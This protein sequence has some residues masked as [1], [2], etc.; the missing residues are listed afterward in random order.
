MKRAPAPTPDPLLARLGALADPARLRLLALLEREE[1]GVGE[2]AEILQLPQS[3]VSRHLKVLAEQGWV[4]VAQRA[5]RQSLL[6]G[7]RRAAGGGALALGDRPR[8]DI[9]GWPTLEHDRLRLARRLAERTDGSRGFFA[10]VAD[11]WETL[12]AELYGRRFTEAAIAALLPRDWV[13]ADLACGSRRPHRAARAARGAGRRGR[14]FAGD[15]GGGE[16]PRARPRQRRAPARRPRRTLPVADAKLRRGAA[17]ARP[18]PRRR[19]GGGGRPR[20]RAS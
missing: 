1:L 9:A 14:R 19:A 18:D 11:Q 2:L 15:A 6:D 3:S 13:V 12:R 16:A 4:V 20:W 10:G 17:A 8:E 5:H 7:E